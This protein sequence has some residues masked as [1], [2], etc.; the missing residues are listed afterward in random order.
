MTSS[1]ARTC[2]ASGWRRRC[3]WRRRPSRRCP[4]ERGP[5]RWARSAPGSAAS[6][7]EQHRGDRG[8]QS[9]VG[10]GDDQLGAGQP[11]GLERAQERGPER[12]VLG[13]ADGEAEHLPMPVGGHAGGDHHRLGDHPAVDPRLAVGGIQEQVGKRGLGQAAVAEGGGLGVEVGADPGD[14]GLGD[15]GIGAQRPHQVIDLA[16]GDPVQVCLHHHREQ[17]LVDPPAPFPQRRKER[18]GPQLGNA[19]L[20]IPGGRGQRPWPGAVALSSAGLGALMRAGTDHRGELGL[21][22]G[23]VD[24]GGR[25]PDAVV[26][27]GGLQCL[28]HLEQG[29]LL[30]GHRVLCPSART[31]GVVSLTI[32]RWPLHVN[33]HVVSDPDFHHVAGR[34]S[35]RPTASTT[36]KKT[37]GDVRPFGP[38]A[39]DVRQW[40]ADR[41][42]G[43]VRPWPA[44]PPLPSRSS[45]QH[46]EQRHERASRVALRGPSTH[47]PSPSIVKACRVSGTGCPTV[48]PPLTAVG[49]P[50]DAYFGEWH[51]LPMPIREDVLIAATERN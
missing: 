30:Q 37:D 15:A 14:L 17:R 6:R 7:A 10:V 40:I 29:S 36:S 38:R 18:P 48:G 24:R 50:F 2:S 19:Q 23:L 26:D 16:G 27:I 22:Q 8:L 33:A 9:G 28:Q 25:R 43:T 20:Q 47:P 42:S 46:A 35:T 3:G 34:H 5:A 51:C 49:P 13:V 39:G 4:W 32:T 44:V 1:W 21:D 12:P 11:A 41:R 31:I 45:P